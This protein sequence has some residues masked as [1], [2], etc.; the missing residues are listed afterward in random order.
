[1][2]S[3]NELKQSREFMVVGRGSVGSKERRKEG[4]GAVQTSLLRGSG[5]SVE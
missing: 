1:M 4:R 5:E 3:M 2:K